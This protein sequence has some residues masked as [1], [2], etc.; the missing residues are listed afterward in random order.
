MLPAA[1]DMAD[2][3]RSAAVFTSLGDIDGA[4]LALQR[5]TA[6]GLELSRPGHRELLLRWLN[7]W[8]CRIR[9]PR[10]GEPALFDRGVA[11]WWEAFGPA[12]PAASLP[13]LSDDDID[14][15]AAA[16]AALAAINVSEGRTRRSLGPTAAAK[17]LYALRPATVMPWDA[18]IAQRLHGQRDGAAFARHQRLGRGWAQALITEAGGDEAAVAALAARPGISLAKVLDE[19]LYITVTF[20]GRHETPGASADGDR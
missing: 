20:A 12:L 19:Y 13:S 11:Q 17:A 8:G 16:Y 4:W 1:P 18:A 3:R 7:S 15:V 6:P 10:D 9:Y 2:L 14:Q 5:Q